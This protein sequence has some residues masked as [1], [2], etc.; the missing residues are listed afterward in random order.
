MNLMSGII[1][2]LVA[3]GSGIFSILQYAGGNFG[4]ACFFMIIAGILLIIRE[5]GRNG[6]IIYNHCHWY[7]PT[8][9][10]KKDD[11]GGE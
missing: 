6:K 9:G 4:K 1:Y 11:K 7:I 5:I 3:V 8:E 10:S 2:L